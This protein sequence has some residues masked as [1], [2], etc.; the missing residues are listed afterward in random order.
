L[1]H[2]SSPAI[3]VLGENLVD[4]LVASDRS[5]QALVGGGPFNVARTIGRLGGDARF[6]SG[7]SGDAFGTWVRETLLESGVS[8]A[9]HT[10]L[11]EPTTLAVVELA[12]SGPNYH[13]HLNATASFA[14]DAD[15]ATSAL[16]S[17]PDLAAI[18]FG[19]LGLVVEPMA[20][21]GEALVINCR[22]GTL[23]VID[24]NCRPSAVSDH[25]A[26]RARVARLCVRAHVVKVSSEDLEYLYPS[27]PVIEAARRLMHGNDQCVIVTDGGA[28]VNVVYGDDFFSLDVAP[29]EVVDTVGA[30]DALVGGFLRYWTHHHFTTSDVGDG[31]KL[32]SAVVAAIEISRLTCQRAGA[33]PPWRAD[34]QHLAGWNWL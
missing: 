30:G 8:L 4:L 2:V 34:V 13:F 6:F 12:P 5:V 14:L 25:E 31:V 27:S 15:E 16:A 17:I 23:I 24:P 7:V 11:K 26:Y 9:L 29:T 1:R 19:T 32:K 20:S 18:Y 3:A 22:P 33:E 21:W 10:A 28:P